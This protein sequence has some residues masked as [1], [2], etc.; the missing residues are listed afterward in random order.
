[1]KYIK[2]YEKIN[3]KLEIGDYVVLNDTTY[4]YNSDFSVFSNFLNN[5]VGRI[6][7]IKLRVTGN[8]YDIDYFN[9]PTDLRSYFSMNKNTG[10]L[11]GMSTPEDEII[12]SSKNKNDA[13]LFIQTNKY[14]L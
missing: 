4:T 2:K 1:M 14:N 8:V 12:F 6:S 11:Y 5:N 7:D 3:N 10:T 9:V 13:E